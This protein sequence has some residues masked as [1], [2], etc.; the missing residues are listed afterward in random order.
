MGE[1]FAVPDN[2]PLLQAADVAD[3][4]LFCLKTPPHVQIHEL[5]IKPVG[6]MF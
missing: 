3:A 6:E 2:M 4:V 5:T 1:D